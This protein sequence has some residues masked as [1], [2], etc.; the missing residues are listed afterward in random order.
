VGSR[1]TDSV[2]L[3]DVAKIAGVSAIT[4]S[5]V[6]NRPEL[7]AADTVEHVQRVI[8]RTGYVPNLLAGGLASRRSHLVAALVPTVANSIFIEMIQSLTDTLWA[9]RYQVVLGLAGYTEREDALVTAILSRRPDA[10]FVVGVSHS[11][12]SRR[13]ILSARIPVVEAWDLTTAPLDMVVGFS[14]EK[15]GA[16][17][18]DHLAAKGYRRIASIWTDDER[19]MRRRA[20]F[21]AGLA[22]HGLAEAGAHVVSPPTTLRTGR[23]GLAALL[24]RGVRLDAVACSSD[25]IAHGALFEAQARGLAVPRKLGIVGFG[26]LDF[27]AETIPALT[28]VRI[29]RT[30]I[31]RIAAESLLARIEG[32]PPREKVIDVGF[33]V[34]E[35]ATT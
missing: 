31:G 17:V 9:A 33:E 7:V 29:D 8:A 19:A 25:A 10:L 13:R 5:R 26:D 30:A 27:A 16:A 2:T 15:V 34:I 1:S 11:P 22:R 14:H 32:G 4:V 20:G 24:D 12:E 18:A 6:V 35:R 28:T 3:H 23:Q 21:L